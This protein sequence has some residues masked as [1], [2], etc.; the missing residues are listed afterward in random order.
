LGEVEEGG[1]EEER[2]GEGEKEGKEG[3]VACATSDGV[4]VE[5]VET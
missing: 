2:T 4:V 3:E 1:K 5:G